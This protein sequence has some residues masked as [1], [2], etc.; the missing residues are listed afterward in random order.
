MRAS[1]GKQGSGRPSRSPHDP[2]GAARRASVFSD[3]SRLCNCCIAPSG[4][5]LTPRSLT[6]A[7]ALGCPAGGLGGQH[8]AT[9]PQC[10]PSTYRRRWPWRKGGHGAN[11]RHWASAPGGAPPPVLAGDA[12]GPKRRLVPEN[13]KTW[14]TSTE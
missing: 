3:H 9:G 11:A 13:K 7:S 12:V 10:R 2:R 5:T 14:R 8:T 6:G 4:D 1:F